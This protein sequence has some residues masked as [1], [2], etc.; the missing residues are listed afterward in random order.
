MPANELRER[1]I[2]LMS[3]YGFTMDSI[4]IIL[5]RMEARKSAKEV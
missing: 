1:I 5:E 2:E 4:E 3:R